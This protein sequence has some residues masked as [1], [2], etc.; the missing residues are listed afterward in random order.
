V[1]PCPKLLSQ[2]S[3]ILQD[4]KEHLSAL[5]HQLGPSL[6]DIEVSALWFALLFN[7][8]IC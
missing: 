6:V 3:G 8:T 5:A 4:A 2:A 1:S 7:R